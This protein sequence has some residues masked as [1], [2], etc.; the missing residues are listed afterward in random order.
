MKKTI[1][2]LVLK[3]KTVLLRVDFNVPIKD[4]VITSTKRIESA[5]P[6]IKK[7]IS[8]GGKTVIFS[9]LGRVKNEEDKL[10]KDL[11]PVATELALRLKKPVLFVEQTRGE[12]LEKTIS[13]MNIGD[14]VLVQN[15]RHED[16]NN[17]AES[18]NDVELSV[19]W[20][21]LGDVYINDAFA[22]SHRKHASNV[23]ISQN[24]R[25]SAL[26]YLVEK[27]VKAFDKA[28]NKPKHPY[29][30][31]IGGAKVSDKIQVLEKLISIADKLIVG[32]GMAY[33]FAKAEGREVGSSLVENDYVELAKKL[34]KKYG[35]K[36]VL[37]IDNYCAK[38][39]ADVEAELFG[40]NIPDGYMGLDIGPKTIELFKKTLKGAK[41]I[42]WNGPVGVTEFE[43]FKN[44]TY[45]LAKAVSELNNVYSVVGGGDIVAAIE[46]LG[47]SDKFSHV[48]TGGGAA[49]EL[50][51]GIKLPGIE[52]IQ[53]KE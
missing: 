23:G 52:A 49:L 25:E 19:Y 22:T 21:S 48:S 38:E 7:I 15:T 11:L 32:G 43:H 44:G 20:A 40:E 28:I 24:I 45:E 4:G 5:L 33:T 6:T 39:F 26:G 29:V 30:A 18:K 41:T 17:K 34:L 12:I 14:V 1:N 35:K 2:D 47:M 3:D 46:K 8:E 10:K 16:L 36:I 51:Q 13:N 42:V 50:L 37:P 9:H 31:I 27:E 53:D